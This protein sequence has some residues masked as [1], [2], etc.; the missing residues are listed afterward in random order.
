MLLC[1]R[2]TRRAQ[3]F[4]VWAPAVF[5]SFVYS[6]VT[7]WHTHTLVFWGLDWCTVPC[8]IMQ[9]ARNGV[10]SIKLQSL[11]LYN[12]WKHN[13]S[14][15]CCGW[16]S[17]WHLISTRWQKNWMAG[18]FALTCILESEL[19]VEYILPRWLGTLKHDRFNKTCSRL[20]PRVCRICYQ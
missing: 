16:H 15:C 19:S 6:K 14:V 8:I 11:L 4:R 10:G 3:L 17:V 12:L 9:C 1:L 5:D 7:V 13:N 20:C 18:F 2:E